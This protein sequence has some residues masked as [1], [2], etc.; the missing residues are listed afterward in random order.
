VTWGHA[1][2]PSN[3]KTVIGLFDSG[4][5]GLW[6]WRE[7]TRHLPHHPT[8]Y[9]ADSLHCPY[10]S[11]Q[12][13]EVRR[14]SLGIARF[15]IECGAGIIVVA[16][17]TASA[18][19]LAS[20]RAELDVAVVGMEPAVKPAAQ[21]TRTGH[22]GVLATAG[23]LNGNL[24]RNTTARYANGMTVHIQVGEGLVELVEAGQVDTPE[25]VSLLRTYL[26]PMLDAG[27]DQIVLGCTHYSFLTPAIRGIVPEW[28]SVVDP[29][30]A[31]ARR[32][33]QMLAVAEVEPIK[34]DVTRHCPPAT[35]H[36]FTSGQPEVLAATVGALTGQEPEVESVSW[37]SNETHIVSE[38][39][40]Q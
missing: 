31:V 36:F 16:C 5:G 35:M 19:G 1:A 34:A 22:V 24:F 13:A 32:V 21:R 38:V 30:G 37:N 25:T 26:R 6:I 29:A 33:E 39:G 23:T 15:L 10:G 14:F 40:C 27:V 3:S 9:L 20:L 2:A 11:R 12:D 28:V 8:L 18:A 4:I 17:N 7:V